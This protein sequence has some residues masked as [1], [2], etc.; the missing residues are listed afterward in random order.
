MSKKISIIN[1][2]NG[3]LMCPECNSN[4]FRICDYG[5]SDDKEKVYFYLSYNAI[6]VRKNTNIIQV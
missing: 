3:K 5:L 1:R 4:D 6:N 2:V